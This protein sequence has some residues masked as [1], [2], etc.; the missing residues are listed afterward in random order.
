MNEDE[1]LREEN[2]KLKEVNLVENLKR[3]QKKMQFK[4]EEIISK[5][6]KYME[7]VRALKNEKAMIDKCKL[8]VKNQHMLNKDKKIKA[9]IKL[10]GHSILDK[11]EK[12]KTLQM[13]Q[14]LASEVDL[15]EVFK[16][17]E[18]KKKEDDEN[19]TV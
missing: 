4:K 12:Q 13:A 16:E 19:N 2:R 9:I 10:Q 6:A 18:K 17:I 7:K 8:E 3:E 14:K 5:E 11:N 1:I 15:T